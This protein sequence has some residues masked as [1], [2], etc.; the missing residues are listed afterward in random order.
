VIL[1]IILLLFT[2]CQ[3]LKDPYWA[4]KSTD[5]SIE[6]SFE[7]QKEQDCK[8]FKN[9]LPSSLKMGEVE[10]NGVKTFYYGYQSPQNKKTIFFLNGGPGRDS[11]ITFSLM[12]EKIQKYKLNFFFIDQR[13][14]GCSTPYPPLQ[15]EN[16]SK[17][18]QYDSE[19]I[20][21]DIFLIQKKLGIKKIILFA[22]SYGGN[23]AFRYLGLY[24][25]SLSHLVTHGATLE[26]KSTGMTP[27]LLS[28][29]RIS[30]LYLKKYPEDKKKVLQ[31]R[32]KIKDDICFSDSLSRICGKNILDSSVIALG[33]N[34]EWKTL[35]EWIEE[36]AK[37]EGL[38]FLKTL[39]RFT[40]YFV[41]ESYL[42]P[43]GILSSVL[44]QYESSG[45]NQDEC[46]IA[47]QELLKK[48][49]IYDDLL[50]NE[51]RFFSSLQQKF[52]TQVVEIQN[53]NPFD[54]KNLSQKIKKYKIPF[55]VFASQKDN[56]VPIESFEEQ[57]KVFGPL[58]TYKV[59]NS[60]GHDGFYTE[61]TIWELLEKISRVTN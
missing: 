36:L 44:N 61:N 18:I 26:K 54:L 48:N 53:K 47:K 49:I 56:F 31:I 16:I 10:R 45:E 57:K 51:C 1:L 3:T 46:E 52:L 50:F 32:N 7:L 23:I 58:M 5:I 55:Y 9:S 6:R 43:Q 20:A 14:T 8:T 4:P 13:G 34:T 40:T 38:E 2:G 27:R 12:K 41:F 37:K 19:N 11:H 28:Q 59:L 33:F 60:S 30:E 22:Q 24:P 35:H 25:D 17:L 15:E 39:K 42:P 21:K 29:Q